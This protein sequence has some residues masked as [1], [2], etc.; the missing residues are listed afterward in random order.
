MAY[1]AEY[2]R[3]AVG[4]ALEAAVSSGSR[5]PWLARTTSSLAVERVTIALL[6]ASASLWY[7]PTASASRYAALGIELV[8]LTPHGE[9]PAA[10]TE[11]VCADVLP[12]LQQV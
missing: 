4:A 12:A 6:A 2:S 9:D 3:R 8:T 1:G 7:V 5:L 10:W 11:R